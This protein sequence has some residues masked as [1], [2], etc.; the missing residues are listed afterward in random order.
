MKKI[1]LENYTAD[2]HYPRITAAVESILSSASS[3]APVDV[4]MSMGLIEKQHVDD[5]RKGRIPYLEKA[6]KCN[7]GKAGRVLRILRFHAHDLN[8]QPLPMTYRRSGRG[9]KIPLRFSKSGE[10]NIEEAYS[11]H[12]VRLGEAG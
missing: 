9:R 2:K 8:L 7:L 4:F 12:F 3:V 5:W 1:T 6:I 10:R 11:R